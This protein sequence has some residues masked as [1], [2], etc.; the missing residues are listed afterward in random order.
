MSYILM[1]F[2]Y[3]FY[4]I[5]VSTNLLR[6][7]MYLLGSYL[8]MIQRHELFF[9]NCTFNLNKK[10]VQRSRQLGQLIFWLSRIIE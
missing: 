3:L 8:S 9:L 1:H 7:L 5:G 10:K 4:E 6:V 2:N